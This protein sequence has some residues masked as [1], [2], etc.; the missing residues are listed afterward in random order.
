MNTE[1][2]VDFLENSFLSVLLSK[3][4]IT[5]IS[6]N[7]EDIFY[8]D[9]KLGRLK[10]EEKVEPQLIKDFIRQIANLSEKQ[11]SYQSPELDVS[12]GKY[13]LTALHQSVCRKANQECI[14]FSLRISSSKLRIEEDEKLFPKELQELLEVLIHSNVSLVIG[15]L[16]G[17][18]K[19]ELQKYLI[20][21]MKENTRTIV[22]DNVLELDQLK[23]DKSLDLNIWQVDENRG[24]VSTQRLV[25][26]ALRSNPDWLIVAESR[27]KEALDILNSSL[28]GHP[29]ITT[30]HAFDV[31]SMPYRMARMVMMN[32]QKMDYQDVYQDISYHLRFYIY[33]T[34]NYSNSGA[35]LRYVSSI[36]YLNGK[37]M[38]EI[39][40]S[41]GENKRF[42]LLSED[43]L[44]L[45]NCV[46]ASDLFKR[47]FLGGIK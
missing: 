3:E 39:Y 46:H 45:L 34:R 36:C 23:I 44:K 27:G 47:T 11:F 31:E 30:L 8:L 42:G 10:R 24:S 12:F 43:A 19:T 1:K 38:E 7:G 29:I 28:T 6:Y 20:S 2:L 37:K 15:G 35:V 17:S 16:T 32:E 13:R 22:I 33:L 26:T 4:T 21:N 18:G 25:R 40:G 41:D 14:S 9:N 5:D